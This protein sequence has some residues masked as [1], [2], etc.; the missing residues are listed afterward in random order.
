MN[1][2]ILERK[3]REKVQS[4]GGLALKFSSSFYTGIPDRIVLM[5][6]GKLYFVEVK[7]TGETPTPR[8]RVVHTML[9]KM[10]FTVCVIDTPELLNEFIESIK[11]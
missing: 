7:S 6:N 1:E 10:G 4:L 5:E 9:Q 11:N 8:Q 2:K 3:L